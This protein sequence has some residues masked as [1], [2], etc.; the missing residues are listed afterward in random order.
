M[1]LVGFMHAHGRRRPRAGPVLGLCLSAAIAVTPARAQS[2]SRLDLGGTVEAE[3]EA[4]RYLRALQLIGRVPLESWSIA[5]YSVTESA[6]L[7]AH[8]AGPWAARFDTSQ[9]G[10]PALLRPE[11]RILANSAFPY[12]DGAGPTWAGRGFTL[13]G[14][15]GAAWNW[16]GLHLQL[17]P[18][19]YFAQN[20]AFPLAD[21]GRDGDRRLADPRFPDAIDHP[22]RFGTDAFA[23]L[24]PG[25]S[26]LSVEGFRLLAGFTTAPQRW[27]PGRAFP[28]V[29]N[30][31]AGGFPTAFLGTA[32]AL[33]LWLFHLNGRVVYAK[34]AQSPYA[35]AVDSER[36]RL[37]SGLVVSV[38]PRGLEGLELGAARFI[39]QPW[40]GWP[41]RAELLRPLSSGLNLSSYGPN[42]A[43]ENQVASVFFRAVIAPAGA[44]FYGELFREDFPGPFHHT[45]SLVEKPDDYSTFMLGF[46]RVFA[47]DSLHLRVVHAEIVNGEVSHQERGARGF[48]QPLPPYIHVSLTQGHTVNG[49]LLGSA[50]AYGGAG[51]RIGYDEFTP[52]G[53]MS[54]WFERTLR[55]DWLPTRA[56]TMRV[57]PDVQYSV[58]WEV[59]RFRGPRDYTLTV[60]PTVNLNRNLEPYRDVFNLTAAIRARGW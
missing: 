1:S 29:L 26:T 17:A 53:R 36:T 18:I 4:D 54:T 24:Q 10:S 48:T 37:G 40:H 46:Q 15:A 41:G 27:G 55:F 58:R 45:Y 50:A 34:L 14:Q 16:R 25:T 49:R 43:F 51:W 2:Y 56:D 42:P 21:N 19:A 52:R 22:Q 8:A 6:A 20:A 23:R 9:R 13:E 12:Q 38:Q 32:R 28:L 35:A 44:E 3:G 60:I 31:E 33:N 11:A 47:R 30:P 39:H 5:P 7:A 57:H 59:M